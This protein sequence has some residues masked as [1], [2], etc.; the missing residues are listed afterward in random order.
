MPF[1]R[2][3]S[4]NPKGRPKKGDSLAEAIRAGFDKKRRDAAVLAIA[5]KAEKGDILAFDTLAK[6]GWP[7]EQRPDISLNFPL[8]PLFQLPAGA[9]VQVAPIDVKALPERTED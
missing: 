4:G 1:K 9:S 8:V 3:S 6:R 7:E 5:Q 2:G